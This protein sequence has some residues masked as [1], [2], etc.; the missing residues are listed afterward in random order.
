MT[1]IKGL[2]FGPLAGS[3]LERRINAGQVRMQYEN[4]PGWTNPETLWSQYCI[5]PEG[6]LA[7]TARCGVFAVFA[8]APHF[9]W[10][11]LF[12]DENFG[13]VLVE[14]IEDEYGSELAAALMNVRAAGSTGS[15]GTPSDPERD[16]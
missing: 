1:E 2:C 15:C 11:N 6:E 9:C 12:L 7:V 5:S 16:L 3:D 14:A 8:R 4:R 13:Q 10:G